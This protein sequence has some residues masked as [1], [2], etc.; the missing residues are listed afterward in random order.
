[1]HKINVCGGIEF[2]TNYYY[3][4]KFYM[5]IVKVKPTQVTVLYSQTKSYY[6]EIG[7]K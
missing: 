7:N 5:H 4:C 1:M 6:S 3:L 2:H